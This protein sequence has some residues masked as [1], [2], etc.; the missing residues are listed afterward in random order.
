MSETHHHSEDYQDEHHHEHNH[1]DFKKTPSRFRSRYNLL[2]IIIII[3]IFVLF[4]HYDL[5]T[6]VSNPQ[7]QKNISY[8]KVNVQ[9]LFSKMHIDT[10]SL[11]LK[12][13]SSFQNFFKFPTDQTPSASE[14]D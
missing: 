6:L 11:D 2:P 8:I 13:S 4:F 10:T 14:M 1:E 7:L 5:K 3:G 12:K 9:K